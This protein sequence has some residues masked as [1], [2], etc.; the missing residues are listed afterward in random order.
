MAYF[1]W[2]FDDIDVLCPFATFYIQ[3]YGFRVQKGKIWKFSK[4]S[5]R[6]TS[7]ALVPLICFLKCWMMFVSREEIQTMI[8]STEWLLCPVGELRYGL[9]KSKVFWRKT[10][11]S[12]KCI[13]T[14]WAHPDAFICI[15]MV[16]RGT[17]SSHMKTYITVDHSGGIRLEIIHFEPKISRKYTSEMKGQ[18][19]ENQ[20]WDHFLY[21]L[22]RVVLHSS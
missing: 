6:L 19:Q 10:K 8:L 16:L 15:K 7:E 22:P 13:F 21:K 20:E 3:N 11:K 12:R 1:W 18:N 2:K 9:L 5:I 4:F 17:N 14:I